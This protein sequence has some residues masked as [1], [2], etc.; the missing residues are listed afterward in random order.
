MSQMSTIECKFVLLVHIRA[1]C[2]VFCVGSGHGHKLACTPILAAIIIK[3]VAA[4]MV[5]KIVKIDR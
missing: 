2:Q 1:A 4:P 5:H 3:F